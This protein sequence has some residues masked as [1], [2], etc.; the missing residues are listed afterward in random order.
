MFGSHA[1]YIKIDPSRMES[2]WETNEDTAN[3][4]FDIA[5]ETLK[6]GL[7]KHCNCRL[8]TFTSG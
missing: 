4:V 2:E 5:A 1:Q 6:D 8:K 7:E 3:K